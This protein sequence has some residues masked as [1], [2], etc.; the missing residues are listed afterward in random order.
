[1]DHRDNIRAQERS[2]LKLALATFALYLDAFEARL[3]QLSRTGDR[4]A[5]PRLTSSRKIPAR[6]SGREQG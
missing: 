6:A 2:S 1:M 5:V 4:P 3:D